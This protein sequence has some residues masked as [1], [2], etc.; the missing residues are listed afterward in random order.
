MLDSFNIALSG[1]DANSEA[2]N[3][4]GDNLANLNTT[5][6]KADSTD[7]QDMVSSSYLSSGEISNG[8]GVGQTLNI[9]QFT[10]G[11]IESTTAPLDA[12]IQ[13]DGFF[14]VTANGTTQ[15]T[16]DGTFTTDQNGNLT[17]AS[18]A[19]VQGWMASADGTLNSSGAVG[20]ITIPPD[21]TLPPV[22]TT[23]FT[24]NLNL[25]ASASGT[26]GAFSVPV[27][28][29]DSLGVA[30]TLTMTFTPASAGGTGGTSGSGSTATPGSWDYSISI[31]SGDLSTA[32]TAPLA[33]GT[34]TFDSS[35]NLTAPA[36]SGS[37]VAVSISG[38]ADG[39]ADMSLNWNLYNTN[40]SPAIT[41]F[42]SASATS[43][44]TQN[45]SAT[46]DVTGISIAN[47]GQVVATY[48]N[49]TQQV[50]AQIAVA[51]ISNPNSLVASGNNNFITSA[52]TATPV[53]GMP[54]T[55]G[56]GQIEGSS[57][58]ESNVD[59]GTEFTN[60]M[61]YERA[62]Q[63]DSKVIMTTDDMMQ[64]LVSLIQQ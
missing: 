16:R 41:Q 62:Y 48:S 4:V 14:M 7:F 12:A 60:L 31:P 2:I 55:G 43:A 13:G 61:V 10:P 5:G 17:T 51:G 6:Y 36:A 19:M 40:G 20:N 56:R 42:A 46:A 38:L 27:Q 59:I 44:T 11:T 45:G 64:S 24:A 3:N 33:T 63:A 29:Y 15:Y 23:A 1:L 49:G 8:T 32:P 57:L 25:D 28:V 52:D 37:P 50:E 26:S 58:E 34:L 9:R 47:G 21:Q 30:H 39:A 35:G 18:G 53:V 22:A 54:G